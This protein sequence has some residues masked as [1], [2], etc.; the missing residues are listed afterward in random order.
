M[1]GYSRN[2]IETPDA[3]LRDKRISEITKLDVT[4]RNG[5]VKF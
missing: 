4:I 3:N 2:A 1:G 5:K